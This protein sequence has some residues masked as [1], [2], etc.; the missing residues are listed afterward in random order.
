MA[1][2]L[3]LPTAEGSRTAPH[4]TLSVHRVASG[5]QALRA[6]R[7]RLREHG[8]TVALVAGPGSAPPRPHHDHGG[9]G[10]RVRGHRAQVVPRALADGDHICGALT[11]DGRLLPLATEA[12]AAPPADTTKAAK[13]KGRK[14]RKRPITPGETAANRSIEP[15][16]AV[17]AQT[18]LDT[19][20]DTRIPDGAKPATASNGETPPLAHTAIEHPL[21]W[22][23]SAAG[24]DALRARARQLHEHL[25]AHPELTPEA[26]G[27]ALANTRH[28]FG[29]RAVILG[30]TRE[31]LLTALDTMANGGFTSDA[32]QGVAT[33]RPTAFVFPGL[34]VQWAGMAVELLDSSPQFRAALLRCQYA[35]TAHTDWTVTDVLRET[36]GAPGLDS[37][38]VSLPTTFAVQVALAET[39]QGPRSTP[40]GLRGTQ[41][42]RGRRRPPVRRTH[43]QG[44][45]PAHHH[46]G[47]LPGRTARPRR[48]HAPRL[49][50]RTPNGLD[51]PILGQVDSASPSAT[52]QSPSSSQAT[53]TPSRNS[54]PHW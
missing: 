27:L 25:T 11:V 42:G 26:V 40:R 19:T 5:E 39:W 23:L 45:R 8:C 9:R 38:A 18:L 7:T 6:A 52:A 54:M 51:P 32:V 34:G 17:E 36:N 44:R 20:D 41:P 43:P 2:I 13:K 33:T 15:V 16:P 37:I 46:L 50:A 3:H 53:A 31:Q 29:H 47:P 30:D 12:V 4:P 49:A 35:L 22:A 21:P 10:H 1:A 24:P 48:G 14:S 28:Q